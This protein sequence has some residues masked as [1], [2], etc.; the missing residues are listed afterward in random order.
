MEELKRFTIQTANGTENYVCDDIDKFLNSICYCDAYE[1]IKEVNSSVL[2][3]KFEEY[4]NMIPAE[5]FNFP[6]A[7]DFWESNIFLLL[8]GYYET[9]EEMME[10][11]KL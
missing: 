8:S 4:Y 10:N 5:Q 9:F 11:N 1:V 2:A 7:A 6:N 3:E